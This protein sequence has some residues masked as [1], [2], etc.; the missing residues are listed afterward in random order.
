MPQNALPLFVY[1]NASGALVAPPLNPIDNTVLSTYPQRLRDN[2]GKLKVSETQNL[3]EADFEYG[4][5]PMRWEN[6]VVGA[7]SIVQSSG[8]G[9]VIMS[10]STLVGDMA[11]RQT[12]PY[13]RYQPGKTMYM[14]SG[15]LFGQAYTNQRQRVGFFDD[16][17]GIFWEQ[18]DPTSANP[19]GMGFVYRSDAGGLPTDTRI[20]YQNWSDPYN[21][22][23][24]INWNTIQMIWIEY[25]WYGAGLLRWGVMINGEPWP[26][27]Q[28]GVGNK[29]NQ[30][31]PWSRTGNFPIR[32]ELRNIG[33]STAG[34]MYHYGVSVLAEGKI[35]TQRGFTYGYGIIGTTSPGASKTRLPILSLRYRAMGTLEYGVDAAYSGANGSLPVGGAA[36]TGA[37]QSATAT[38]VTVSGTPWTAGQW[39][40]KY[41]FTRGTTA[42]ITSIAASAGSAVVTTTAA[43][44]YLAIGRLVTISG[45]TGNTTVNGT[46]QVTA[47]TATTFTITNSAITTGAVGGTL[48]YTTGQGLSLIH[49]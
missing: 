40:G 44:N 9:G 24:T 49:I 3:F 2:V 45:A 37:V 8:N 39:V 43:N 38:T 6:F 15:F 28:I 42:A 5:Q 46:F 29:A 22:K 17:N 26:L 13:I 48:V 30:V 35:D 20:E 11:I 33:P 14:A 19:S 34:S 47:A 10:V 32:Y 12:R 21:I 1:K 27:H 25:A 4:L 7:G 36:I 16:G 18:G 31:A 41:F 23:S